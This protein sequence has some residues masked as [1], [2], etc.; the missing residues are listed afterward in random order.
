M[1]YVYKIINKIN[2]KIYIGKT[3]D[4]NQRWL[5]H[6][7]DSISE[8]YNSILHKAINKYGADN[9]EIYTI[10]EC[11]SDEDALE[12]EIFWIAEYKTN[13]YKY[14]NEFG[15]N[16]TDGGEGTSGF[17]M[18]DET[19]NKISLIQLGKIRPENVKLKM[20]VTHTGK[21]IGENNNSAKLSEDDV[22][23]IKKLLLAG[24]SPI[25]V[26]NL[27]SIKERAIRNIRSGRTWSHILPDISSL[28][29]KR[30][31]LDMKQVEEIRI[32]IKIEHKNNK[33]IAG[34]YNISPSVISNIRHNKKR[35]K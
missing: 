2:G 4:V 32:L 18:S 22:V 28:K 14:G 34:K 10:E 31:K 17:H 30:T 23:E 8:R 27:Y 16:L 21:H 9:F 5:R 3:Y 12:K 1:Y 33:D 11:N 35:L 20:S 24:R 26:A 6:I 19:K 13:I 25:E 29:D 15:Y 7:S